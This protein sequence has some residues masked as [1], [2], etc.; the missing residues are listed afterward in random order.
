M[1]FL[2]ENI[3][4]V[5]AAL[6]SGGMLLWPIISR[7]T[8][9]GVLNTLAAT[10]MLN[11]RNA[12][13]IDIRETPELARGSVPQARHLAMSSFAQKQDALV[14]DVQSSKQPRPVIVMCASGLRSPRIAKSLRKA[15]LAEVYN[16]EGGF[17]A[18]RQAGLPIKSQAKS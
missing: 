14:K 13:L 17:D 11:S 3:V 9:A 6:V 5:M 4:L 1:D 18:W 15:G 16:L 12:L 10:Q 7:S 2:I 8:A